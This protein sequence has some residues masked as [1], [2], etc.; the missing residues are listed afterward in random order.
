[1]LSNLGN[2]FALKLGHVMI[3]FSFLHQNERAFK[4]ILAS[5]SIKYSSTISNTGNACEDYSMGEEAYTLLTLLPLLN[6][7]LFDTRT[8]QL[9]SLIHK[10]TYRKLGTS[11]L[12]CCT[13]KL[14]SSHETSLKGQ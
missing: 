7:G 4:E 3:L 6:C 2:W 13:L 8:K 14:L 9:A 10:T 11:M 12:L 5:S 1:M